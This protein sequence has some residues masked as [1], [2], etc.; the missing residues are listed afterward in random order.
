MV[1]VQLPAES[2]HAPGQGLGL[3]T[4]PAPKNV[5]THAA[6]LETSVQLPAESQHAPTMGVQGLGVQVVP[7]PRNWPWQAVAPETMVQLPKTSQHAP[8]VLG[9]HGLGVQLVAGNCVPPWWLQSV[10]S[11]R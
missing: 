5:P 11:V 3:Q 2:Q 10:A 8:L 4:V 1:C 9:M 6:G 7:T